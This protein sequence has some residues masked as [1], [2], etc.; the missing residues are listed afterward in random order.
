[1]QVGQLGSNLLNNLDPY[2]TPTNAVQQAAA[3]SARTLGGYQAGLNAA[4]AQAN[5]A[6]SAAAPH[7]ALP[8]APAAVMAK[9]AQLG[10]A[11]TV[12]L[13]GYIAEQAGPVTFGNPVAQADAASMLDNFNAYQDPVTQQRVDATMAAYHDQSGR[14]AAQMQAQAARNK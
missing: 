8:A 9:A 13:G 2:R 3:Q 6:G 1:K 7:A 10:K 5:A 11:E 12:N 4:T 14:Q